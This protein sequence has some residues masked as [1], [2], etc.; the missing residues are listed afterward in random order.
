MRGTSPPK[1][2]LS[3][4]GSSS[5]KAVLSVWGTSPP[6]TVFSAW[7]TSPLKPTPE[8]GEEEAR[9]P[10]V[11]RRWILLSPT[12]LGLVNPTRLKFVKPLRSCSVAGSV[13]RAGKIG[14]A[15][16]AAFAVLEC[17][18]ERGDELKLPLDSCIEGP[19]FANAFLCL[20]AGGYAELCSPQYP[21]RCLGAQTMLTVSN[22]GGVQCLS[23]SSVTRLIYAN[24]MVNK[25][26]FS[27]TVPLTKQGP[28]SDSATSGPT[29]EAISKTPRPLIGQRAREIG[30]KR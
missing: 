29:P 25:T 16:G 18:I 13:K 10:R 30:Q 24:F 1:T 12:G 6:K 4:R 19:P 11:R 21:R 7:G 22:S 9:S 26:S 28:C 17:A 2:V 15:V 5:P 3:A 23:E 20:V 14:G 8:I 27:F